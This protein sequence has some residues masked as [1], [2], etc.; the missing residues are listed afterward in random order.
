[1]KRS[2]FIAR[3]A[4]GA[5][6]VST[7]GAV[8][9]EGPFASTEVQIERAQQGSPHA[10]KVLAAIQPHADDIPIFAAGLVLKLIHEGYTGYLIRTTNDDHTGPGS[11]GEGVLA[12]ER[13]NLAVAKALG[14][15]RSYDLYYRNHML[16]GVAP[17]ELRLR[18]IF[19]FRLLKVDTVVCYDPWAHYEENPDHYVTARAVEAACWMAG[20]AKD[21]PEHLDAGLSP[22]PVLEKYYFARGPQ[23]VNRVVDTSGFIEQKITVNLLNAAQGPAGQSGAQLR[24]RLAQQGLRLALLGSDDETANREYTRQFVLDRDADIGK[25]Y[26]LSYAE[27]Y[28]YIGREPAK[29]EDYVRKNAVKL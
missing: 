13:D 17:L 7:A 23:Y 14:L 6:A 8:T 20:M 11:V 29:V 22:H 4:G 1:M 21:Y 27:A 2:E 16:D 9:D 12:N 15:K 19:L 26:G 24:R 5:F 3:V 10:G 18:L 25:R 28:H